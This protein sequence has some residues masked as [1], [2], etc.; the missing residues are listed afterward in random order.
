MGKHF[1]PQCLEGSADKKSS[2]HNYANRRGE[3]K[4]GPVAELGRVGQVRL[5]RGP[6][7]RKGGFEAE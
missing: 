5:L 7:R 6:R 4:R 3:E 1:A 2:L